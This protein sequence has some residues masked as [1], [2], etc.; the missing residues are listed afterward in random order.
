VVQVGT[1]R[2]RS[3]AD[4]TLQ[5]LKSQGFPVTVVVS[6][7]LSRVRVGPYAQKAEADA[8]AKKL[9]K[10]NPNVTR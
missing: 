4:K 10:Y 6:G 1:F 2:D 8:V 5:E 7:G 3:N 9:A